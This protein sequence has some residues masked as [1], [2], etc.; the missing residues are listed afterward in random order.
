MKKNLLLGSCMAI[1]SIANAQNATGPSSSQDPFMEPVATGVKFTSIITAGDKVNGYTACGILDGAGAWDN[2]DGTFTMLINQEFGAGSGAVRAHGQDGAFISKWVIKKDNLEVISGADLIQRIYLW[3]GTDFDLFSP[4]NPSTAAST[5]RFCSGDLPA[6]SAF[7]NEA[8]G[9]G[10]KERIFMNGEEA[11][12]T[13]RPFGHVA[14]GPYAGSTYELPYLGDFSHENSVANPG[15]GDKTVVAGTDDAGGG[16]I[17]IY[18]GDKQTTGTDIEKAGLMGG[19]L[20]GIAVDNYPME[21]N[22]N[23]F[24]AGTAFTLVDLGQVHNTDGNTLNT[25]SNNNGVTGFQ[26]PEDALWDPQNPADLY[27]L[28]TN[29]FNNPSRLFRFRFTDINDMTKGGT[30]EAVLDGTEGTQMMDNMGIDNFGHILIEEDPGGNSYNAKIW[31]YD[32]ATDNMTEI[33]K[34]DPARFE[35]GGS[36]FLTTNEEASGI[37]DAQEILGAGWF[38]LVDQ[39]HTSTGVSSEVRENGQV[40]AMYN[41]DS[42][43]SNPEIA[44]EGNSSDITNGDETPDAS[45]NTD[46]GTTATGTKVSKTFTIK[47][48]GAADLVIDGISFSGAHAADFTLASAPTFP[49]TVAAGANQ[50]ITVEFAPA[51][52]GLRKATMEIES[53]DFDENDF[54][55]AIQGVGLNPSDVANTELSQY[56][57]L[58][59]NPARDMATVAISL[60]EAQ[61]VSVSMVSMDGKVVKAP[62]EQQLGA[63]N[64]KVNVSTSNLANG[65]YYVVIAAGEEVTKIQLVV[66]H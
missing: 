38:L 7:W 54:N 35:T 48:D 36:N 40:L 39:A 37:F 6:V 20:Y 9:K 27:V 16:Q 22:G 45:D 55:V 65:N 52:T 33:A 13:G 12:S 29:G 32:I 49:L 50:S 25:N 34:H 64:Q 59:P 28:T 2:G 62:F 30:V 53:N 5:H 26:R 23:L 63:G 43:N 47:N 61:T 41:P 10:T 51:Q 4:T 1:A 18:I 57:K 15:T 56:V 46:F 3:N 31:Q 17:Y 24:S 14:T 60:Q 19:T 66:A 44:L 11:G 42:Y 8:T 21:S 58:Y